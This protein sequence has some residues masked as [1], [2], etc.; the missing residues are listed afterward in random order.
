MSKTAWPDPVVA[1]EK[2][3]YEITVT[4]NGPSVAEQVLITDTLPLYVEYIANDDDCSLSFGTGPGGED[5][6]LCQ[7]DGLGVGESATFVLEG[8]VDPAAYA[9]LLALPEETKLTNTVCAYMEEIRVGGDPVHVDPDTANNCVTQDIFLDE[10]ADLRLTKVSKPDDEVRAGEQFTY[11][12]IVDNYGPSTARNIVITDTLVTSGLVQA[13]GCSLSVLTEGGTIDEFDCNFALSTGVFSLGTM[14]ANWLHPRSPTDRGRIIITINLTADEDIDL[15][16]FATVVAETPDPDMANNEAW[17][18]LSVTA[19]ADLSIVKER[20][21]YNTWDPPFTGA[22]TIEFYTG[23]PILYTLQV[24]NDGPSEAENIVVTDYLPAG[25][26]VLDVYMHP[27]GPLTPMSYTAGTPG[28]PTDPMV[29]SLGTVPAGWSDTIMVE[30]LVDPSVRGRVSGMAEYGKLHND[31][32]I[33]S[34]TFD[35]DTSDNLATWLD[36]DVLNLS[37]I[38]VEKDGPETAVAGTVIEYEIFV[39]NRGPS[40][41]FNLRVKDWLGPESLQYLTYLGSHVE[42]ATMDCIFSDH[43]GG[44]FCNAGDMLAHDGFGTPEGFS[45]Y[46]RFLVDPAT[47]VGTVLTNT[48]EILTDNWEWEYIP[49]SILD[50]E[51]EIVT[52]ANLVATK[53][54]VP[55]KVVAGEQVK[56]LL[57]VTN[58]GPSDAQNVRVVDHV[59]EWPD[60]LTFEVSSDPACQL[61]AFGHVNCGIGTLP[62]GAT[63]TADVWALVSPDVAPGTVITNSVAVESDTPPYLGGQEPDQRLWVATE[64]NVLNM[65]DLRI[66][67]FGKPDGQVRAGELLTYTIVVDNLAPSWAWGVAVQD[68]LRSELEFELVSIESSR[69]NE[70]LCDVTPPMSSSGGELAFVC[71]LE[72]PL[73]T[74]GDGDGRWVLTVV[75]RAMEDQDINNSAR[76]EMV[77]GID[78]DQSNNYAFVMHEIT[79]VADLALTKT[80]EGEV[81][82]LALAPN[83]VVAGQKLTY[84]LEVVNNGPS[85]AENV[86][87]QDRLPAWLTVL[88]YTTAQGDCATGTPGSALDLFT[89]GIG[90]LAAT[91]AA[92]V[93]ITAEVADWLGE[94][95]VLEND[96]WALSDEFDPTNAN[97]LATNLTTVGAVADLAIAKYATGTPVAGTV[98]HYEYQISNAGPSTAENVI[99]RDYIP[100][101]MTVVDYSVL[102]PGLTGEVP[103]PCD[104][105]EGS[106]TLFC[107]LGS[108]APTVDTPILVFVDVL[109]ESWVPQDTILTNAVDVSLTDTPDP[110]MSNNNVSVSVTV[111]AEADLTVEKVGIPEKVYAGEQIRYEVVV[112][113]N[114]PSDAVNVVVTDVLDPQVAFELTNGDCA[115]DAATGEATCGYMAAG[116]TKSFYVWVRVDADV[117][118]GTTILNTASVASE[119]TDPDEENNAISIGN[120]VESQANLRITKFGK[121][122]EVRAGEMLTYTII[123]DNLGPSWAWDV[124]IKEALRSSGAFRIVSI[125]SNLPMT[126]DMVADWH[127]LASDFE[128]ALDDALPVSAPDGS[129]RWI[130]TLVVTADET[131]DINNSAQALAGRSLDPIQ[132]NNYALVEHDITDVSDLWVTKTDDPDPVIAGTA[133]V[134]TMTVGNDGPSTAENVVLVDQLPAWYAITSIEADQGTCNSVSTG[135]ANDVTCGLGTLA[136]G[137]EATVV[138]EGIVADWVPA[139]TLL[140]NNALVYSDIL[141][142]DN[143]NDYA[144]ELTEV[145]TSA[146]LWVGKDEE[147][148]PVV[149]GETL[150]WA[151]NVTNDGP[152]T[153]VNVVAVDTLPE[154]VEFLSASVALDSANCT[155]S[156]E[157]H[158]VTC[159]IGS[160]AP[161]QTVALLIRTQ[162]KS[163]APLGWIT[164]YIEV[165]SDP[166]GWGVATPD[167]NGQNNRESTDT[168]VVHDADLVAYKTSTPNPVVAGESL[169]YEITVV[170]E[171]PSDATGVVVTDTLPADVSYVADNGNATYLAGPPETLVFAFGDMPAGARQS[172]EIQVFVHTDAVVNDNLPLS[173]CVVVS[174]EQ[175]DSS[176]A[177]NETCAGTFATDLADL[178]IVK[179]GKPDDVVRAGELL[180]Y[181]IFVDNLGPSDARDVRVTD[182]IL[183]D[184]AWE[185]VSV[186]PAPTTVLD[187][188]TMV[189]EWDVLIE[190]GRQEIVI[191]VT[192]DEAQS[193]NNLINVYATTRDLDY[194]NNETK[195]MTSVMAVADLEVVKEIVMFEEEEDLVAGL[196]VRFVITATNYGPSTAENVV[197]VDQLPLHT[198]FAA[199]VKDLDT[200]EEALCA[201]ADGQVTCNLGTLEVGESVEV[202]IIVNL[203]PDYP[204]QLIMDGAWAWL[205]NDAWVN[206]DVFDPD[207]S[208]N[209]SSV[210]REVIALADLELWKTTSTNEVIAGTPLEFWFEVYNNGPSMAEDVFLWDTLPAEVEVIGIDVVAGSGNCNYSPEASGLV[211]E[212][213]NML[214]GEWFGVNVRTIV[215]DDVPHGTVIENDAWV[216]SDWTSDP[217]LENNKDW[218]EVLVTNVADLEIRKSADPANEAITG[219]LLRYT[220]SVTNHGPT[221]ARDVI[222]TDTLPADVTFEIAT[223]PW[224]LDEDE[225]VFALGDLAVGETVTWDV[226][227]RVNADATPGYMDNVAV[228]ASNVTADENLDNNT[229]TVTSDVVGHADLK[230]FKFGKP[231]GQVQAG[232]LL[233]YTIVVDNLGPGDAPEVTLQEL[234]RSEGIFTVQS[235]MSERAFET[236]P[237]LTLPMTVTQEMDVTLILSDTLEVGGRWIVTIIAA[238][239]EGLDLNNCVTVGSAY[240]DPDMG[241]NESCASHEFLARADLQVTKSAMGEVQVNGEPGG[242]ISLVENEVSAGRTLTYAIVVKNDGPSEAGNVTVAD[243]LPAGV[244]FVGAAPDQGTCIYDEATHKLA[245][246]LGPIAAGETVEIVVVMDV[247]SSIPGGSLLR[248]NVSVSSSDGTYDEDTGNN[249]ASNETLVSAWSDLWLTKEASPMPALP[250]RQIVYTVIVGNDG[251]SDA[252][253][254]RVVDTMPAQID[255]EQWTCE[256]SGRASCPANGY[257]NLNALVDLPAGSQVVFTIV[258][259]VNWAWPFT[260]TASLELGDVQDPYLEN[261]GPATTD[262][263]EPQLYFFPIAVDWGAPPFVGL[264]NLVIEQIIATNNRVLVTV[265]NVGDYPVQHPF[266]VDLYV[267]PDMV[268]TAVNQL[269][270]ND[271]TYGVG[272]EGYAW[273][274]VPQML[275][276]AAG[277][278]ML[279]EVNDATLNTGIN[280]PL[281][282]GSV[283]Y[284]QV[285]S[286]D[287]NTTYGGVLEIH[288]LLGWPYD[289]IFGP[290]RSSTPREP[291][292]FPAFEGEGVVSGASGGLE[293]LPER[294][295]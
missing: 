161:G 70:T 167:P 64:S 273:A 206:S 226:Y 166:M 266:W 137:A 136:V 10:L 69:P 76:V 6:V 61:D 216:Q 29:I 234:M 36:S 190:G 84:T 87:L 79:A 41:A 288:E 292:S 252:V 236:D 265:K 171:G 263:N 207:N 88:E 77:P 255:S 200:M 290:V 267:N 11:T 14:G 147:P 168:Q 8:M 203:D 151:F 99:L 269:W 164:N 100:N 92:T 62:A 50:G 38:F 169:Y 28:D 23:D 56:Y 42:N 143:S 251:P 173:N 259:Q 233:T 202:F 163:D 291:L 125:A 213:G 142:P 295:Q 140:E 279:L 75:V 241:N 91:E 116:Q 55:Q 174:G 228:V 131:Q 278:S 5:E 133:L 187:D 294:P 113:N 30:L 48:V 256:A 176:P 188:N 102:K 289:N 195:A 72:E 214:P 152:S 183:S 95:T 210:I 182:D 74:L 90:T 239:D 73:E 232:D 215:R 179:V 122:D 208:N 155:Y 104:V 80:A 254:V 117:E 217:D 237:E 119:T 162:V 153:A 112:T 103:Q 33:D 212:I 24:A 43:W 172:V 235:I 157:W 181:T 46:L 15:N 16:N 199:A 115:Y 209:Q 221:V 12:I 146:D 111:Q 249:V 240:E 37:Y 126:T 218:V 244:T 180:T 175:P 20:W 197:V 253:G 286:W 268:P 35:D 178:R 277:E 264:P 105:T 1:G 40:T 283:V 2:V 248:N 224:S 227:V 82:P 282:D 194:S 270:G 49:D 98:M 250:G 17:D 260:N 141:D 148:D 138:I 108:V 231:D 68:M 86:V 59:G 246:D 7:V 225:L 238:A 83:Q 54:S 230:V 110:D 274:I 4:N 258:G 34:D 158:I 245:C 81:W 27:D 243:T 9:D 94:G 293:G 156:E 191:V 78:P 45:I 144:L 223:W 124:T 123:V 220:L 130:V 96:A 204:M 13:N 118:P 47:P 261:N 170:N 31:A 222:V 58:L 120:Y 106:N 185:L 53:E 285:D 189:W 271:D 32:W 67:K 154:E 198:T 65:A 93:T 145:Q 165:E 26:V 150:D 121:M 89:C 52:E 229:A 71:G 107:P 242:V 128:I 205:Q 85:I 160:L 135:L 132:E 134:Y 149:A 19:V 262:P 57:S 60:E 97:N 211:C 114:G 22:W 196:P 51:T 21:N 287:P 39:E 257:G 139:G 66:Q 44:V 272:G 281:R 284:A 275:P 3:Y 101:G 280:W 129:G 18:T 193:M 177:N 201:E 25:V 159:D 184:L 63:W 247:P 276:L 219:G 109:I 186:D 127:E 192:G